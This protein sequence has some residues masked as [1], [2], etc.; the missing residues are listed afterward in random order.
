MALA[1]DNPSP[2]HDAEALRLSR[3]IEQLNSEIAEYS[4]EINKNAA[5]AAGNNNGQQQGLP[6]G[7]LL[8]R[9]TQ[10]D[11]TS[12]SA[13]ASLHSTAVD[14]WNS[15]MNIGSWPSTEQP[16]TDGVQEFVP[17]RQWM[18]QDPKSVRSFM[19]IT[20][21][22]CICTARK[23]PDSHAGKQSSKLCRATRSGGGER[24]SHDAHQAGRVRYD[25]RIFCIA[26]LVLWTTKTR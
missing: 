22:M 14:M 8:Q 12:T 6:T 4:R 18:Y 11:M 2:A 15:G 19:R 25:Y 3:E 23:R 21:A 16:K 10:N 20:C 5:E 24:R 26:L 9:W 13:G 1:G 17:G 7:S